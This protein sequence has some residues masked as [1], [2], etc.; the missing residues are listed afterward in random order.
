MGKALEMSVNYDLDQIQFDANAAMKS[1][2]D[3][4]FLTQAFDFSKMPQGGMYWVHQSKRGLSKEGRDI[5]EF[6][7]SAKKQMD[8]MR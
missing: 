1:L 3:T 4:R 5:L 2:F 8:R 6:M 7:I